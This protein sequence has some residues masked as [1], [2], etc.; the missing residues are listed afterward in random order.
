MPLVPQLK[1]SSITC[2]Y[3]CTWLL[4]CVCEYTWMQMRVFSSCPTCNIPST[5]LTET[6]STVWHDLRCCD[7]LR[8]VSVVSLVSQ[9]MGSVLGLPPVRSLRSVSVKKKN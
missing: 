2:I 9:W 7:K 4:V 6:Q 5:H 1:I 3:L 8:A